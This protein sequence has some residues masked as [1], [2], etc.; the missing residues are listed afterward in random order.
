MKPNLTVPLVFAIRF[1][2]HMGD[3]RASGC[4]HGF[5]GKPLNMGQWFN[6]RGEN[7]A[8]G[9]P[10][11]QD[12]LVSFG[13]GGPAN[14]GKP[15]LYNWTSTTS[16]LGLPFAWS[17]KGNDGL[18]RSLFGDGA[19]P[20]FVAASASSMT[21]LVPACWTRFDSSGSFG[22][23]TGLSNPAGLRLLLVHHV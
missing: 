18:M 10:S 8:K 15:G 5:F 21:A 16:V 22:L 11:N 2:L 4:D 3:Q 14:G 17:P 7:M 23:A 20:R 6:Q 12:P 13:L 19:R 9:I 1:S